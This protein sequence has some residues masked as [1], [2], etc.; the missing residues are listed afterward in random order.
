MIDHPTLIMLESLDN[1][2]P[3]TGVDTKVERF[4]VGVTLAEVDYAR[5]LAFT[6]TF[7]HCE[8]HHYREEAGMI[9][10]RFAKKES[11]K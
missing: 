3:T 4:G 7:E 6:R 1:I 10:L 8:V 2:L 9:K 11:T 5:R